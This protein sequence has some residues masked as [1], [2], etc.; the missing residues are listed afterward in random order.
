VSW[1]YAVL[2]L[3]QR[4]PRSQMLEHGWTSEPCHVYLQQNHTLTE[5]T[6]FFTA[7]DH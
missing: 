4:L 7:T 2:S 1:Q 3:Y 6:C 5:F